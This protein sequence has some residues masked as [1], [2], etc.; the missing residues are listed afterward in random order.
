MK[1][2]QED[3]SLLWPIRPSIPRHVSHDL[4][5]VFGVLDLHA[6][7]R[8]RSFISLRFERKEVTGTGRTMKT[9]PSILRLAKSSVTLACLREETKL[10]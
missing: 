3:D 6:A 5:Q 4:S 7:S 10:W 1:T 8:R 2:E 9:C